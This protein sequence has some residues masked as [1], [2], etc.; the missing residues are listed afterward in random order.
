LAR[1]IVRFVLACLSLFRI[2]FDGKLDF[3]PKY[4]IEV[5]DRQMFSMG[6][7]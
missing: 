7:V 2:A 5:G 3:V 1:G 4:D 6:I